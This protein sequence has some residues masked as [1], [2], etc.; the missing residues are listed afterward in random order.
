MTHVT[1]HIMFQLLFI[2]NKLSGRN[3][4]SISRRQE[5]TNGKKKWSPRTFIPNKSPGVTR[6]STNYLSYCQALQQLLW[7][8]IFE[9]KILNSVPKIK[10]SPQTKHHHWTGK[11]TWLYKTHSKAHPYF[12]TAVL[13]KYALRYCPPVSNLITSAII[14]HLFSPF[15]PWDYI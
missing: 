6:H 7:L 1:H 9:K 11:V 10:R 13:T 8:L 2:M 15:S 4:T 14:F 5:D 12:A 3:S